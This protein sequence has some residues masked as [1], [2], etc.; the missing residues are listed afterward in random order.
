VTITRDDR[1]LLY[2][3][4]RRWDDAPGESR[5]ANAMEDASKA[6]ATKMGVTTTDLRIRMTTE[7]IAGRS[8]RQIIADMEAS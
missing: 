3:A 6:M 5:A 8:Q 7:R 2:G 4:W 1:N